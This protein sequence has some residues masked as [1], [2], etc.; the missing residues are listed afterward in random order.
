MRLPRIGHFTNTL[1]VV[2]SGKKRL[3]HSVAPSGLL[4]G[5]G[6]Y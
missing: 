3:F 2:P 6:D 5:V 1:Q 4:V